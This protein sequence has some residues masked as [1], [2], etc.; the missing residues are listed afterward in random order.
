MSILQ[1]HKVME[2]ANVLCCFM[3]IELVFSEE[4]TKTIS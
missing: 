3:F 4:V 1:D 2:I